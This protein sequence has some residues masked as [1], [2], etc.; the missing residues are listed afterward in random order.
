MSGDGPF[1]SR[2]LPQ[3]ISAGLAKIG[4][5]LKSEAW[6]QSAPAG[7]S[8]TQGQILALLA[9]RSEPLRL[10]EIAEAL[11]VTP[12][13]AS[14]AV[15]ALVEKRMARKT[16]AGDDGRALAVSLTPKG[17]RTARQTAQWPDF[18]GPA[19][20]GLEPAEQ[21]VLLRALTKMIRRLQEEGRIPVARMCVNCRFFRPNVHSDPHHP[22]HCDYVDA[23]FGDRHLRLDCPEFEEAGISGRTENWKIFV[24]GA[25]APGT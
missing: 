20:S 13:T 10:S 15:S 25:G 2:D 8:P 11:A 14:E 24:Q 17:R 4:M 21:E 5:A 3:R 22:H 12:A 6:R 1:S 9:S 16:K 7:L 19:V 18:L 23:A